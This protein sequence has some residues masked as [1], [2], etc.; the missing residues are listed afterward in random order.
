MLMTGGTGCGLLGLSSAPADD[1]A[2]SLRWEEANPYAAAGKTPAPET[3]TPPAGEEL[4]PVEPDASVYRLRIGDKVM[5]SI[6]AAE[7][8]QPFEATIDERG[9]IN[10]PYINDIKA[11]GLTSSELE[12]SIQ[13]AYLDQGIYK[14]CT[15]FVS[16]PIR[17]YYVRGEVNRPGQYP[18]S[19][20]V[21]LLQAIAVAGNYSEFANTTDVLILRRGKTIRVNARDVERN[22]ENDIK[23]E[24]GDV[25]V[26]R[27]GIL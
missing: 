17:M 25:I 18:L 16:V 11:A 2:A 24:S 3:G 26:V 6:R 4:A 15:V 20:N 1:P 5:V 23:I 19:E 27:R 8:H 22:P 21:T 10:L 14:F 7:L 9:N 12:R 13:K